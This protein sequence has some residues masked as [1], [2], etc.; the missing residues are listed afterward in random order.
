MTA[1]FAGSAD[2]TSGSA[3]AT[4]TI[5]TATPALSASDDGGTFN[6]APFPGSA[7][8]T[9]IV[10]GV[11]DTA[12][13]SLEGVTPTLSYYAAG[14]A[15]GGAPSPAGTYTVVASFAGS[16]DYGAVTST[17]ASF[18]ITQAAPTVSVSD[19]AGDI[20]GSALIAT[21]AGVVP[22]VDDT[23]AGS[24]EGVGLTLTFYSGSSTAG[25]PLSGAP[26]TAGTYT[27]QA[28]FAGSTDYT[29]GSASTTFNVYEAPVLDTIS[30]MTI[31]SGG[32][33]T[34]QVVTTDP[35]LADVGYSPILTYSLVS[36]PSWLGIDPASGLLTMSPNG[37]G[38]TDTVKVLVT[39]S[40]GLSALETFTITV[41]CPT[42]VQVVISGLVDPSG[43][44][45]P[46]FNGTQNL[47]GGNGLSWSVS[48]DSVAFVSFV[49][50][51]ANSW[52]L[53]LMSSG[54]VFVQYQANTPRDFSGPLT[55][56]MTYTNGSFSSVPGS[57][58]VTAVFS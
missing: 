11:D 58:E 45:A 31:P 20:T 36:G 51:G 5:S 39:D 35:N 48:Y 10:A 53:W 30:N 46:Y 28:S 47:A 14:S 21:V 7:L 32:T 15:L 2:Y 6:G 17:P 22:G 24:L 25:T 52:S 41:K 8:V 26:S 4:F 37:G 34:Y 49:S 38:E 33:T 13:S 54:G 19:T 1:D 3:T 42:T 18:T 44:W 9:G 23:P 27:V 29:G 50:T 56:G 40:V 43:V 57:L 16:A 55:V 12:S